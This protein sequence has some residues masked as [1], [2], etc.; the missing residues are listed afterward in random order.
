MLF[1]FPPVLQ[2]LKSVQKFKI[3]TIKL[4]EN[5]IFQTERNLDTDPYNYTSTD[6][7]VQYTPQFKVETISI[8]SFDSQI[9][10]LYNE[11]SWEKNILGRSPEK[12]VLNKK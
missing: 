3:R 8:S 9:Y 12:V 7:L 11:D 10:L 1:F 5:T 6:I 4:L 2:D